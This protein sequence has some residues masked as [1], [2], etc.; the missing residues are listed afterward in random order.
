VDTS[1]IPE[2]V[3]MVDKD[4]I[5]EGIVNVRH[6]VLTAD[7]LAYELAATAGHNRAVSQAM[8]EDMSAAEGRIASYGTLLRVIITLVD[9]IMPALLD[10]IAVAA[11]A[12][13]F[14]AK[15]AEIAKSYE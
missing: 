3:V 9:D 14:R 1:D 2:A 6:I 10:T 5:P 15:L 13:D 12:H 4:G 7:R 11:P 8:V